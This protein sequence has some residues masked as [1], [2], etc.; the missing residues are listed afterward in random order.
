M[1]RF[2]RVDKAFIFF[3]QKLNAKKS[4]KLGELAEFSGWSEGT[5]KTY[6]NKFWKGF[7]KR[8]GDD[9]YVNSSFS[10]FTRI[11][12][13]KHQ[14]QTLSIRQSSLY[15]QLVEKAIAASISAI[16]IYNKP[17]FKFREETFSILMINGWEL[18]LKAKIL[19]INDDDKESILV[20]KRGEVDL[21]KSGDPKT[22]PI[23]KALNILESKECCLSKLVGDNIRLLIEIRDGAVHYINTDVELALK[24]QAVGMASLK[25]FMTL[26]TRWFEVD[27]GKYNF[28][29]MP[30]SFFSEANPVVIELGKNSRANLLK[31]IQDVINK[32]D[33]DTDPELNISMTLETKL[34]KS[35]ADSAVEVRLTDDLSATEI[36]I[37]EEDGLKGFYTYKQLIDILQERY[38]DFKLN[39]QFRGLMRGLKEKGESFFKQRRLEPSNPKSTSKGYYHPRIIEELDKNYIK[40]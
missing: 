19:E 22:I 31:R 24:V 11:S 5:I 26:A 6:P 15:S 20:K 39:K 7:L 12:F 33:G 27:F 29:L 14:S 36:K 4:F 32:H 9:Y 23:T 38:S 40:K 10:E 37:T 16:E 34:V 30:I 8:D 25:N 1:G 21:T 2:D 3:E 35:S 17:D 28:Y 18:L 13:R